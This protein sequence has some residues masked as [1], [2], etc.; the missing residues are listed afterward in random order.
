M[1]FLTLS[2]FSERFKLTLGVFFTSLSLAFVFWTFLGLEKLAEPGRSPAQALLRRAAK[3]M[4]ARQFCALLEG[5]QS[6]KAGG[7]AM[8]VGLGC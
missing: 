2:S 5:F 6:E 8:S 1:I 7:G 3:A 4:S